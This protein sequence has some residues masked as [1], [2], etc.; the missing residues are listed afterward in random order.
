MR[1][2]RSVL[3]TAAGLAAAGLAGCLGNGGYEDGDED[4]DVWLS[5]VDEFDGV[6]DH[7]GSS[8]V[9]VAVG[10]GDGLAFDPV[11]IQVDQGTTVVW[12]WTGD[13][14]SHNVVHA[15]SAEL[16]ESDLVNR[17]GH[18]FEYTFEEE[19][20]FNYICTP[21]EA[22]EMKGSVVVE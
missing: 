13:G 20:T 17:E 3:A 10:A 21:H 18:T 6:E 2:R 22:S 11:A 5:A 1:S 19:G 4:A 16:F 7:T 15:G 14:G 8:E 12:E 9:A